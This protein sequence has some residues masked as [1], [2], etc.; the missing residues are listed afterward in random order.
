MANIF[1]D[2]EEL[3]TKKMISTLLPGSWNFIGWVLSSLL[4][5]LQHRIEVVA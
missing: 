1:A 2:G 4:S 5:R 3:A